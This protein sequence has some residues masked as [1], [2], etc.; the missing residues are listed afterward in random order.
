MNRTILMEMKML[1]EDSAPSKHETI[2]EGIKFFKT[3]K[4]IEK[5]VNKA[6][7]AFEKNREKLTPEDSKKASGII[8][9]LKMAKTEFAKVEATFTVGGTKKI[10]LQKYK[11]LKSKYKD[12]F[13]DIAT[14]KKALIGAGLFAAIGGAAFVIF[15]SV[16]GNGEASSQLSAGGGLSGTQLDKGEEN[17][18][19]AINS[20]LAK[21]HG[22]YEYSSDVKG[23]NQNGVEKFFSA[24]ENQF[25][26]LG[27]S[28]EMA[29][30]DSEMTKGGGLSGTQ[31]GKKW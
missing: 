15:N 9:R 20:K 10:A 14:M 30:E 18:Q 2:L 5:M 31:L 12:L 23:I 16:S 6:E 8:K 22:G 27:T 3:S 7:I 17:S 25:K 21:E 11:L 1:A 28:L 19:T 24:I 29:K 4:K 26:K 13:T